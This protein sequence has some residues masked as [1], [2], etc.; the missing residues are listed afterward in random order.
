MVCVAT[1]RK[2]AS[3]RTTKTWTFPNPHSEVLRIPV[4]TDKSC[5]RF[6]ADIYNLFLLKHFLKFLRF[7][8]VTEQIANA[9]V[10]DMLVYL[11]FFTCFIILIFNYLT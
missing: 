11:L 5:P 9:M 3:F 8:N 2:R 4:S 10:Y 7:Q 6:Y 1:Y